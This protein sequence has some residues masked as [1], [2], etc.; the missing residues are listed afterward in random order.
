MSTSISG[1]KRW[2][3]AILGLGHWYSAFG[4]ARAIREY[5]KA[6]IVGAAWH[7]AAQLE[8][9][10]RTFGVKGFSDYDALIERDDVDIVQIA[11]PVAEIPEL[12]IRG[13]AR[14]QTHHHG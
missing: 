10:C 12:T 13:G 3:V 14:G 7:D 4:L 1:H 6:E 9:F 2:R 8:T 11:A 5:P